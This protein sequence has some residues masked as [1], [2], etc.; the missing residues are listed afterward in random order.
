MAAVAAGH[1]T[2]SAAYASLILSRSLSRKSPVPH[3]GRMLTGQKGLY[4]RT[5]PCPPV[6]AVVAARGSFIEG[7]D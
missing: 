4:R 5:A 3:E 1:L 6:A 7:T 2:S